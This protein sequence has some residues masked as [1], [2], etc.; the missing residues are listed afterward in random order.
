MS[1]IYSNQK[2]RPTN[3]IIDCNNEPM[4]KNLNDASVVVPL[5]KEYLEIS[6]KNDDKLVKLKSYKG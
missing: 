6:V 5:I 4:V 2:E 3:K 1:D